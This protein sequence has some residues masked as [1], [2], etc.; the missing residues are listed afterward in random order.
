ME[1]EPEGETSGRDVPI[2]ERE[3]RD[4]NGKSFP[5]LQ[6][7]PTLGK[8]RDQGREYLKC[9]IAEERGGRRGNPTRDG[10][11]DYQR[12]LS[13]G[14]SPRPNGGGAAT[15]DG[16]LTSIP[17]KGGAGGMVPAGEWNWGEDN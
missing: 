3:G 10:G 13:H 15:R 17:S 4:N 14:R 16:G 11:I 6:R 12:W 7:F 5:R 8:R 1:G 9:G 2:G